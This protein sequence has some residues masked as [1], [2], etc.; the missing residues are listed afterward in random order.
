M[1]FDFPAQY[2]A[3]PVAVD[4]ARSSHISNK[5]RAKLL[6]EVR[7]LAERY[8]L[9]KR[10]SLEACLICLMR[11]EIMEPDDLDLDGDDDQAGKHLLIAGLAEDDIDDGSDDERTLANRNCPPP[12]RCG[13]VIAPNGAYWLAFR[14]LRR[15]LKSVKQVPSMLFSLWRHYR[16]ALQQKRE[17]DPC[18]LQGSARNVVFVADCSNLSA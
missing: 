3:K 7:G 10:N 4:I 1:T 16:A 13:A 18:R 14:K 9:K 12:R 2:P 5:T 15:S 17:Q 8:A 11:G 6:S